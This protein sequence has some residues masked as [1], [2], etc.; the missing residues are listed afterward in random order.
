VSSEQRVSLDVHERA[1]RVRLLALDVDGTL[2]DGR[3]W[4][5]ADGEQFKAFHAQDGLGMKLVRDAGI[6]VVWITARSS[7]IVE[8]RAADLGLGRVVQGCHDKASALQ[9]VCADLQ[10]APTQAAYMGDDLP[11]RP[12]L[13]LAGLAVVPANAH[14]WVAAVAH[15][16]TT[17]RGGEGAVRELCDLL[18]VANGRR[19]TVL[20]GFGG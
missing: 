18:L 11:D 16:K 20:R 8:R 7:A 4:F 3:L 13:R 19:D 1:T 17:A 9:Q 6:E 14:A 15:W 10:L 2:T 5:G 12:A